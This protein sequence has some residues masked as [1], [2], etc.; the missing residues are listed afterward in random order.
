MVLYATL[1]PETIRVILESDL[2]STAMT[3]LRKDI[4]IHICVF[5]YFADSIDRKDN[6]VEA[7]DRSSCYGFTTDRLSRIQHIYSVWSG[8]CS[9]EPQ[10]ALFAKVVDI[11][12]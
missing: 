7:F 4:Y 2:G 3:A 6:G 1:G 8:H 5:I 10:N 11:V 12:C 9:I